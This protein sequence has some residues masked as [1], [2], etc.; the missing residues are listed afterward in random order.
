MWAPAPLKWGSADPRKHSSPC[1]IIPNFVTPGQ[2]VL[3]YVGVPKI[4]GM[5]WPQ[6]LGMGCGWP[7]RN[8]FLYHLCYHAKLRH[9]RSNHTNIVNVDPLE[10]FDPS[11]PNFQDHSRPL[12]STQMDWLHDFLRCTISQI[13]SNFGRESQNLSTLV[14]LIPLVNF[15]PVVVLKKN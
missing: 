6:F 12:E 9:S 5:L 3:A 1:V 15:V 10:K 11:R 7:L 8:T 2:T 13:N 14:H 4:R